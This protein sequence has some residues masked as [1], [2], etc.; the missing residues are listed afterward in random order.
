MSH[1][2]I[3]KYSADDWEPYKKYILKEQH[4]ISKRKTT[5][6]EKRN[7]D[8]RTHL[9]KGYVEE[10]FVSQKKMICIM[11]LLNIYSIQKCCLKK[12]Y[13]S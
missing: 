2:K 8:F 7:R 3:E 10:R 5:H 6:L 13:T 4:I 11:G 9:K 1:L 12:Q